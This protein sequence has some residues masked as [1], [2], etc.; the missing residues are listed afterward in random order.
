MTETIEFC[1]QPQ[2]EEPL[3]VARIGFQYVSATT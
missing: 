2:V 1:C 3:G